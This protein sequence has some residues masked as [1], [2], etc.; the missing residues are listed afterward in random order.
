MFTAMLFEI[1]VP[2]PRESNL[3][4]KNSLWGDFAGKMDHFM[5]KVDFSGLGVALITPFDEDGHIDW[6]ALSGMIEHLVTNDTDY[7]V[8]LGTT[9]ETPTLSKQEKIDVVRFIVEKVQ[10]RIPVVKGVGGNCTA[11][12]AEEMRSCDITGISAFLSVVPYYNK[13]TQEGLFRHYCALSQASRLPIILYNVPG[14]TGV[15]MTAETTLRIAREC[16]NVVAIKEASGNL[17]QIKAIIDG[18][19]SGFQII[20]GDDA[21][22]VPLIELGGVGVISVFGNAFPREM[23]W[24][25]KHTLRGDAQHARK[26]MEENFKNLF[27]LMFVEGNPAG[28]K[29]MLTRRGLVRNILRLPLVP[30][31]D[32]TEKLIWEELQKIEN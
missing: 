21:V 9:A 5:T 4:I 12:V 3:F 13:P 24:L 15:N 8:A 25:V 31:S 27:H 2:L 1:C 7:I 20:S 26:R 22:T 16:S 23:A 11:E 17:D 10:G 6:D 32:K 19:P 14:R 18:A 30:V 28:V 29:C